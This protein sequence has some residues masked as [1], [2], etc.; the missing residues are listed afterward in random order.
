MKKRDTKVLIASILS[1]GRFHSGEDIGAELSISRAAV[2]K[3]VKALVALGMDIYSVSGKGYKLAKDFQLLD[4]TKIALQ[5]ANPDN[6]ELHSVIESTNEYLL[7]KIR[8]KEAVQSGHTVIAECQTSGRGRRGRVWQSPF[9]SHVYMSQYRSL[10]DGL[11]AAAGLSLVVGL[12]VKK[13]CEKFVTEPISLKWPNDVLC[14]GRKLA[15][16]LIEAEGQSDGACHLIIGI[17]I[18]VDMPSSAANQIDQPWTDL[19][20]LAGKALDR[21][22][23]VV[24]LIEQLDAMYSEFKLNHL[25]NFVDDWNRANAFAGKLVD[26]ISSSNTR[27][28]KCVGIDGT[29]ALLLE[30]VSTGNTQKIYGGEVSLRA[31]SA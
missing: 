7:K 12:A 16:I 3:Q 11:A 14:N 24:E 31:A 22:A 28:G 15:G 25:V 30:D 4:K 21:N 23:F 6:L 20:S 17:G 27:S 9:G 26:L 10:E 13:A 29:G 19:N 5:L 2:A 8:A 1:D 18:N